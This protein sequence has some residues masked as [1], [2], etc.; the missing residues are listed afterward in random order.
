[1][2]TK[3]YGMYLSTSVSRC[4]ISI[5]SRK[6]RF[7]EQEHWTIVQRRHWTRSWFFHPPNKASPISPYKQINIRDGPF[8]MNAKKREARHCH[9]NR[10]RH[11]DVLSRSWRFK[12]K[13]I[14]DG[15]PWIGTLSP[16]TWYVGTQTSNVLIYQ[17][18]FWKGWRWRAAEQFRVW[19]PQN[20][21]DSKSSSQHV[22]LPFQSPHGMCVVSWF[23]FAR[24]MSSMQAEFESPKHDPSNCHSFHCFLTRISQHAD[25]GLIFCIEDI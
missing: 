10:Q 12:K 4:S 21:G 16:Q 2:W 15:L 23:P 9:K 17:L 18:L 25:M 7:V 5:F 24:W 14:S 3:W 20:Q 13:N 19:E 6:P 8:F 11:E 22:T 1:M